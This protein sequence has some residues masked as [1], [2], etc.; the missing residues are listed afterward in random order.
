LASRNVGFGDS[1]GSFADMWGTEVDDSKYQYIKD[2]IYHIGIDFVQSLEGNYY[3]ATKEKA[4]CDLAYFN[5]TARSLL[6]SEEG[7]RFLLEDYRMDP[8]DLRELDEKSL[9]EISKIYKRRSVLNIT[10]AVLRIK[11]G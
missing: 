11:H 10:D 8:D 5:K 1:S 4:L 9:I 2:P 6:N 3:I 7:I